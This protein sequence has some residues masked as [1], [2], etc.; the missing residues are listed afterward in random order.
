M[1]ILASGISK[2]YI[3]QEKKHSSK[4]TNYRDKDVRFFSRPDNIETALRSEAAEMRISFHHISQEFNDSLFSSL[5]F[6]TFFYG[7]GV[8]FAV[9]VLRILL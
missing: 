3:I 8:H 6:N 9:V 5:Q 1:S 2:T 7:T 4:I